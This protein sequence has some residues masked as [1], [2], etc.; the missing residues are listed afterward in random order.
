MAVTFMHTTTIKNILIVLLVGLA[1]N[2]R[3]LLAE[4]TTSGTDIQHV[5]GMDWPGLYYAFLPCEDCEGIKTTLALNKNNTYVQ[6]SEYVGKSIREFVEKGKFTWSG[7]DNVIILTPRKGGDTQQKF[8]VDQDML[9]K[10]DD[11]GDLVTGKHANRYIF[12]RREVVAKRS[13]H[14]GH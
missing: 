13:G 11:N 12:H 6:T 1:F 4:A 5:E 7:E 9:T 8:R 14:S 2:S 10:L 3:V